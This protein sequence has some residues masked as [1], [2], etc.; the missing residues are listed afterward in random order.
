M[1]A[2]SFN[3]LRVWRAVLRPD[4]WQ[5]KADFGRGRRSPDPRRPRWVLAVQAERL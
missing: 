1:T 2:T 5:L 4:Q 3:H